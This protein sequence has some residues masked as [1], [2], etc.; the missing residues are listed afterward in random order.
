VDW[1]ALAIR[2]LIGPLWAWAERNRYLRDYRRLLKHQFDPPEMIRARQLASLRSLLRHAYDTT[3][4]YRRRFDALGLSPDDIRSFA[5]YEQ[6]PVLT[7]TDLRAHGAKLLSAGSPRRQLY[8]LKTS[9]STGISLDI[10]IDRESWQ[11]RRACALRCHE[12]SGWRFGESVALIWGNPGY[13]QRGWRGRFRNFW[14][15]RGRQ[16]DTLQ[17]TEETMAAFARSLVRKPPSLI[18]GHAHSVCLFAQFVQARQLGPIRPRGIITTAM[19]LHPWE[20][21]AIE[22][23]FACPVTNSYGCEEVGYIACECERHDG[24]HVNADGVYVEIL[25]DGVPAPVGTAGSV[26]VTDLSNRGMPLLRYQVGDTAVAS[27]RRCPC[28]RGLPL[29]E[30]LEGREA[31]FVVTPAGALISGISLTSHFALLIPGVV[32]FQIVQEALDRLRFRIVRGPDFGPASV[33]KIDEL[34]SERFG[35]GVRYECEYVEAIPLEPSG[36]YRFC[37]SRV[38]KTFVHTPVGAPGALRSRHR[39]G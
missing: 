15:D 1:H 18:F 30:R 21:Q 8:G 28:G 20:R 39:R 23:A 19:A 7:K 25:C 22:A 9:G 3:A 37:V 26:I 17:M 2:T 4:Y 11:W 33:R 38:P 29:L 27:D 36:K 32:Q 35:A 14:L 24:L 12:W 31:D 6:V 13:V 34:V 10:C 5:D 16:L